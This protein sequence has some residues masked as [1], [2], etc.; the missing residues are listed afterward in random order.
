MLECLRDS[1]SLGRALEWEVRDEELEG[2][3]GP[4]R[5]R[6]A[7]QGQEAAWTHDNLQY[8]GLVTCLLLAAFAH[9]L[10]LI[11]PICV[12]LYKSNFVGRGRHYAL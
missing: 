1:S 2:E 5:S 12:N 11:K 4:R 7:R 6:E 3:A 10:P 8:G 9:L